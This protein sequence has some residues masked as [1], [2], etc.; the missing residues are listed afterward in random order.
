MTAGGDLPFFYSLPDST[1]LFLDMGAS[2]K[3]ALTQIGTKLP[4][5]V[6]KFFRTPQLLKFR[7]KGGKPRRIRDHSSIRKPE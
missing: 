4:E 5:G 1:A 7:I 6:R 3:P 2:L